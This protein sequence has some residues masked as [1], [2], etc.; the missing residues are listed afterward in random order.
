MERDGGELQAWETAEA[1]WRYCLSLGNKFENPPEVVLK[2][3]SQTV[4]GETVGARD[5]AVSVANQCYFKGKS[6]IKPRPRLEE[7]N[8][9]DSTLDAGHHTTRM[10]VGY[11]FQ[12]VATRNSVHDFFHDFPYYN[13]DMQSQRFVAAREGNYLIFKD[14]TPEQRVMFVES[15]NFE[16]ATY[17]ELLEKLKPDIS[18]LVHD[19]Y[20]ENGWKVEKTKARLEEKI[21]KLTQ[22][23]A[24]YVLPVDQLT[25]D[26]YS[27]NEIQLL[28]FLRASMLPGVTD[29]TRYVVA[30]MVE[31]VTKFDSEFIKELRLP[32]SAEREYGV[33]GE[34]VLAQ[35]KEFDA[36]LEGQN[37]KLALL[38]PRSGGV[39][40][41]AVRN[42]LGKPETEL[43]DHEALMMLMDPE[44][45]PLLADVFETGINDH[46]TKCMRMVNVT[47]YSKMSHAGDEQRHR[48]R[49]TASATPP[50]EALYDGTADYFTPLAIRRNPELVK[51]YQE[52]METIFGNVKKMLNAGVPRQIALSLLPNAI[53]VRV[54]E[55]GDLFDFLHRWKQ[56]LCLTAQEEIFFLT[57][58][59]VEQV[60][61]EIPEVKPM[62]LAPCGVRQV[63]GIRPRCPEGSRWCGQQVYGWD[64]KDYKKGRTI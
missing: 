11:M 31:E 42:A 4:E 32:I 33:N 12:V 8:R 50:L 16:N 37:S 49:R 9:A 53:N 36:K 21:E 44:R 38:D 25:V 30:K 18:K 56:R 26:D 35:K 6:V 46:L 43:P 59:Q 20:P 57:V 14:L 17:F 54:V 48:H 64:I 29:E 63:A 1:Y 61:K 45:N 5:I 34:Y 22:E 23:V 51:L 19:M 24:R 62:V 27:V 13:S 47:F 40:A 7:Q 3:A 55:T 15:A 28:R 60:I 10:H 39:L 2:L 58:E 52:R 41:T